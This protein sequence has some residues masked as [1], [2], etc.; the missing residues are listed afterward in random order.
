[1]QRLLIQGI[2]AVPLFTLTI[3]HELAKVNKTTKITHLE[4]AAFGDLT[5]IPSTDLVFPQGHNLSHGSLT[6][7]TSLSRPSEM[8][9]NSNLL[10]WKYN[11]NN[12]L[13]S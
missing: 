10:S 4:I 1:M 5:L 8:K 2:N 11:V 7:S 12:N 6:C 13:A 9:T 3:F